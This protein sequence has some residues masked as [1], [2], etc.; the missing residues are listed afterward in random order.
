MQ[1]RLL[2]VA[3]VVECLAGAALGTGGFEHVTRRRAA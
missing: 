1:T 3:A 2:T